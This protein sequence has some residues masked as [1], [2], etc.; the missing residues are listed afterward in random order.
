M[1]CASKKKENSEAVPEYKVG[2][3]VKALFKKNH[4]DLLNPSP[5]AEALEE[6]RVMFINEV[7]K[8]VIS[9]QPTEDDRKDIGSLISAV[10]WQCF[11]ENHNRDSAHVLHSIIEFRVNIYAAQKMR[12][13]GSWVPLLPKRI[14]DTRAVI[15][16]KNKDDRCFLYAVFLG[17]LDLSKVKNSV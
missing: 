16:P 12:P 4:I 10:E 2:V 17:L 11:D 14:Q 1:W 13:G 6:K 7:L 9:G 8:K 5:E 3:E 15:N